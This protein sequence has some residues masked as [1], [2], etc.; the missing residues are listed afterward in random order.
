MSGKIISIYSSKGGVGK[1][2]V[3]SNLA[4]DLY[5][6]STKNV[7]LIDC[8]FPFF[9]HVSIL[10]QITSCNSFHQ[11]ISEV[12]NPSNWIDQLTKH[13]SGISVI[14]LS[15]DRSSL[16]K[17][18]AETM[19][20]FLM[21]MAQHFQYIV[22]DLGINEKS[23]FDKIIDMSSMLVLPFTLEPVSAEMVFKDMS[24]FQKMSWPKEMMFPVANKIGENQHVD[25]NYILHEFSRKGKNICSQI[26]Y[27]KN[28]SN[29]MSQGPYPVTFMKDP[30]TKAFDRLTQYICESISYGQIEY[31]NL[32]LTSMNSGFDPEHSKI[33]IHE[34]LLQ[35]A[36]YKEIRPDADT[37]PEKRENLKELLAGM[38]AK[39]IDNQMPQIQRNFREAM[40]QAV[41]QEAMGMGPIQDL[42][43]DDEVTDIMVNCYNKIF[44]EKNGKLFP[45][46]KK[47]HSED[48]L[49]NIIVKIVSRAGRKIDLNTP[50][51]DARLEDGSRLH[52]IIPPLA[53]NGA[54]IS[55]RKAP[56]KRL[57]IEDLIQKNAMNLQIAEFLQ[58]AIRAKLNI[59]VAGGTGTG[60]T[61]L[62]NILSGLIP[63][64]ERIITVEDVAELFIQQPNTTSLQSRNQNMQGKGEVSIKDLVKNTLR[65]R[66]DRIIVGECRG[67]E[68]HD[69]LQA[70]NS[71]HEGSLTTIHANSTSEAI[72]KLANLILEANQVP[73]QAIKEQIAKVID[74]VIH[75][76]R[77]CDGSRKISQVSEITGFI[78]G[79]VSVSDIF[80]YKPIQNTHTRTTGDFIASNYQPKCLERFNEMGIHIPREIFWGD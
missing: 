58:A 17:I 42:L 28:V 56:K 40:I 39:I 53:I 64:A 67:A 60:K 5:H 52:A 19:E 55:I 51:V 41:I 25:I 47:F 75:I 61:T 69:M 15:D 6:T 80:C 37:T 49:M 21:I 24:Y 36:D 33:Q 59:L 9:N 66:P 71:G 78:D 10:M 30:I 35:S 74:I 3:A 26:P 27:D 12:N 70:M 16:E 77:Y 44:V 38:I 46:D 31:Q 2:F 62:L 79:I 13:S 45:S 23:I 73:Q 57:S 63:E 50:M 72:N 1:T 54:C 7:L 4:V 48:H 18:T 8:N 43:Y 14:G 34:L 68:S 22:I 32:H 76:K 20:Q 29:K 65:M 11:I